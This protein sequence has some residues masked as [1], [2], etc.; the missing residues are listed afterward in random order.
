[1]VT[2]SAR[3]LEPYRGFH[4]MMRTLPRLLEQHPT[5]RV[6]IVGGNEVSYGRRARPG[7]QAGASN[8]SPS[9]GGRLD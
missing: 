5:A 2:Y 4:I 8:S 3:N 7:R 6:L 9:C 1:V